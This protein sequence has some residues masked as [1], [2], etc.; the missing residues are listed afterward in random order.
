MEA[1][2]R[3]LFKLENE[4]SLANNMKSEIQVQ[5]SKIGKYIR[6]L[7]NVSK[8]TRRIQPA[9]K[10]VS[11]QS[12]GGELCSPPVKASIGEEKLDRITE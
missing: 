2:Y 4:V 9:M 10:L 5:V 3:S 12:G 7:I 11:T 8:V 6:R 1:V